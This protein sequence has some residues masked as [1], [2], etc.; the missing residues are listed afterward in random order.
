MPLL[1][2]RAL[3]ARLPPEARL[4]GLDLGE[5]TIGVAVCDPARKVASAVE[6][7]A[8]STPAADFAALARL[9]AG[10][11]VAA[12]VVGFP[13]NLDG[14]EGPA[15][16]RVRSFI[17]KFM[18]YGRANGVEPQLTLWDERLSTQAVERFMIEE[19]DLSRAKRAAR[20]DAMAATYI[21]QAALDGFARM[22]AERPG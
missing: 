17:D 22:L 1:K 21:L 18:A 8:R 12:Y 2:P 5:K 11:G 9:A 19:A 13:R 3:L 7:L 20:I 14:T 10:R 15:C 6:T 16:A 4:L